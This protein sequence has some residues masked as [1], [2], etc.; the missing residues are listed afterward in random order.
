MKK[1]GEFML[2][3]ADTYFAPFLTFGGFQLDRLKL[4]LNYVESFNIAVDGGAHVGS[5]SKEMASVF[6]TVYAFEPAED[7]YECLVHN[8]STLENVLPFHAALGSLSGQGRVTDDAS[9]KGNTGSRFMQIDESGSI[10]V[11]CLDDIELEDLDFLKLDVEG[12]E[13]AALLGAESTVRRFKP[14]VLIEEKGF[15]RRYDLQ[16]F[17]ASRLLESW[18]A[19][20]VANAGKDYVFIF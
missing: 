14:V 5:W 7:T 17:A 1:A 13:H 16:P 3:D 4:A 19:R 6:E 8:V 10:S 12:F 9:R 20:C 15:G 2:P 18:G 11:V